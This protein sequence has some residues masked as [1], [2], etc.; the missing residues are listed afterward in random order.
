LSPNPGRAA[1]P[2]CPDL[3]YD[4]HRAIW[5]GLVAPVLSYLAVQMNF[6]FAMPIMISTI[7][8]LVLVVISVLLGPETKGK[9]L[10]ADLEVIK[11]VALPAT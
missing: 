7:L 5:G 8:F 9:T 2:I 10:T 11:G 3:I 4:R 1:S 6:G